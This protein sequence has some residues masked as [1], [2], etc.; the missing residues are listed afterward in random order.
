MYRISHR[1]SGPHALAELGGRQYITLL[2]ARD[3]FLGHT[4]CGAA[5]GW[6]PVMTDA[7]LFGGGNLVATGQLYRVFAHLLRI[8]APTRMFSV[9]VGDF[10]AAVV[11]Y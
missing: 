1:V 7:G 4:F 5:A 3:A 10:L 11:A 9:G 2:R 8:Q 6:L